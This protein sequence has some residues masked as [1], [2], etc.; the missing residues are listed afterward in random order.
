MPPPRAILFLLL[1]LLLAGCGSV[2]NSPLYPDT[3]GVVVR[4][5]NRTEI[6]G[7]NL[8]LTWKLKPRKVIVED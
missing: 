5:T 4:T 6:Q 3:F 7:L 1:C 8:G 2:T